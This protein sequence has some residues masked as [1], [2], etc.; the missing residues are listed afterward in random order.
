ML[1]DKFVEKNLLSHI[2]V[3]G[4][5]LRDGNRNVYQLGRFKI[6]VVELFETLFGNQ[7]IDQ[8]KTVIKNDQ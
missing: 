1:A 4:S 6:I 2:S 8:E 3:F 7:Y 5:R